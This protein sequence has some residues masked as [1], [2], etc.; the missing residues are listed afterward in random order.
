MEEEK[1][2]ESSYEFSENQEA[3]NISQKHDTKTVFS[4]FKRSI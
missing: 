1:I 3:S 2:L 4:K